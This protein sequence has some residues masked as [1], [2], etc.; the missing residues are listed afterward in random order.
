M[1]TVELF[2]VSLK[3]VK[4]SGFWS[5]QGMQTSGLAQATSAVVTSKVQMGQGKLLLWSAD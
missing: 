5:L 3:M 4:W 1:A 2:M